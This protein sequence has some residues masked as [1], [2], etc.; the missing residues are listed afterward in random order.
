MHVSSKG[1][2]AARPVKGPTR[3]ALAKQ[4][5]RS[6]VLEAA[7]RLFSEH[8]Y[9]GAT[10]RDIA[11]AAGMSTGAVFANFAD[12]SDLFHEI[13]ANDMAGLR[14]AMLAAVQGTANV[15]DALTALLGAGYAYCQPQLNLVRAAVSVLLHA[16]AYQR[17]GSAVVLIVDL[18]IEQLELAVS[19]GELA[20]D[21]D[22][23]LRGEV[24][25]DTY[26]SN[27]ARACFHSWTA[28]QLE[29]RT[30]AQIAIALSGVRKD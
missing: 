17:N 12:K 5:T 11:A 9:E 7:R 29:A 20:P 6:K 15:D 8:G 19:R 4:E 1:P 26:I 25:F 14:E 16:N 13:L 2:A 30:R 3:R 27:F 21:G 24:I 10:I 18:L 23:R 22:L 28:P